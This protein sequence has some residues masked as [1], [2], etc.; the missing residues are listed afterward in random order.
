MMLVTRLGV[1]K[2]HGDAGRLGIDK[3]TPS[4]KFQAYGKCTAPATP[5]TFATAR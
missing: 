5:V 4:Y 1:G 2:R 3:P